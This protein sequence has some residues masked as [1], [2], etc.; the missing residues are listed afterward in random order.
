MLKARDLLHVDGNKNHLENNEQGFSTAK[1]RGI[2]TIY[3]LD[4]NTFWNNKYF[5]V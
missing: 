5:K 1:L 3:Y 4:K 2:I